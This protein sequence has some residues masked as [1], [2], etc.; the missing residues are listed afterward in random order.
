MDF[1]IE[2][3]NKYLELMIKFQKER[4]EKGEE[5]NI[6]GKR[7][8]YFRD[9]LGLNRSAFCKHARIERTTLYKVEEGKITPSLKT[10]I[11]IVDA[12]GVV[13]YGFVLPEEEFARQYTDSW[14][15]DCTLYNIYKLE[16]EI[17]KLFQNKVFGYY[18]K[19]EA[20][21]FPQG[22]LDLLIENIRASFA[23]LKLVDGDKDQGDSFWMSTS[24][25]SEGSSLNK[26]TC[27][28]DTEEDDLSEFL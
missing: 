3:R 27:I 7:V 25:P 11:K 2:K 10:L 20:K 13:E 9:E 14:F 5:C 21:V 12:L 4:I 1:S 28:N 6:I 8:K 26:E 24:L 19:G 23:A 22:Y 15:S 17:N 18:Q 16:A